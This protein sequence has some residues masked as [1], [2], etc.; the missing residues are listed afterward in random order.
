MPDNVEK[1]TPVA[2]SSA[3]NV[4]SNAVP[5][6]AFVPSVP[7]GVPAPSSNVASPS[8]APVGTPTSAAA[9]AMVSSLFDTVRSRSPVASVFTPIAPS[10]P[11][12]YTRYTGTVIGTVTEV[13]GSEPEELVGS[14]ELVMPRLDSR[15]LSR[16]DWSLRARG[17]FDSDDILT[18]G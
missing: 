6:V 9:D 12:E 1:V 14:P 15:C 16:T 3:G 5:P 10:T 8:T 4:T 2:S 13:V 11:S 17:S 7:S 18:S